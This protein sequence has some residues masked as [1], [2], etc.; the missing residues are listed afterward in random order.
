M[1]LE[2]GDRLGRLGA[3]DHGVIAGLARRAQFEC[4]YDLAVTLH[5][6]IPTWRDSGDPPFLQWMTLTPTGSLV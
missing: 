5:E 3:I 4:M 6:G 1:S 2:A